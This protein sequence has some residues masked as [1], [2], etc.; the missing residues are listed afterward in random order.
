M[1]NVVLNS[2]VPFLQLDPI[3]ILGVGFSSCS[4]LFGIAECREEK[5]G[6]KIFF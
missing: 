2:Q 6:V 5:N 4:F 1:L 3:K